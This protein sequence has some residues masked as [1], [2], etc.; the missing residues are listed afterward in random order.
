M[1]TKV[2]EPAETEWAAPLVLAPKEDGSLAFCMDYQ[3]LNAIGV[4]NAYP[5][6]KIDECMD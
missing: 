2:F 6:P 1:V 3:K 4:R 5:I